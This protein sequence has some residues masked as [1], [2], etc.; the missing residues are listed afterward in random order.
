MA[1]SIDK[2]MKPLTRRKMIGRASFGAAAALGL[3]LIGGAA[4]NPGASVAAPPAG[5]RLKIIVAGGHPG[6]PEYGCGGAIALFADAGHDVAILY[7]NKGE[8]T[9]K[10]GEEPGALR[11]GEAAKAC[12]ILKARPLFAGQI[13][14]KA[15]VDNV[16]Y[17]QFRRLI[18]A[19]KPDVIFTQWPIDNHRD[20]RAISL[21]SYDAWLKSGKKFALYYYEV[22]NGEDTVQFSPTHYVDISSVAERKKSA[23]FAHASQAPERFYALQQMVTRMRGV[24]SG[25][26]EAEGYV[27]LV[28]SPGGFLP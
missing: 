8:G 21:L 23:C 24:E 22:S 12:G 2:T 3:P 28:Q 14:G 16:H 15:I 20:H 25:H 9:D 4:E 13:D 7:L 19:E 27:H 6:D 17:E 26:K 5:K 10:P 1:A 18:E 11:T